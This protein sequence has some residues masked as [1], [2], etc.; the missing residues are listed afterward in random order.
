MT[1]F[2]IADN[3]ILAR[4]IHPQAIGITPSLQAEVVIITID[5]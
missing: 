4:S 5:S 3:D 1:R 2:T